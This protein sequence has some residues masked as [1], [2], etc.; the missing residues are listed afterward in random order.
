MVPEPLED[1]HR[2]GGQDEDGEAEVSRNIVLDDHD[3]DPLTIVQQS[4]E[5]ARDAFLFDSQTDKPLTWLDQSLQKSLET[6]PT[7]LSSEMEKRIMDVI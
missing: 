6:V 7:L 1:N 3:Q 5:Q 4:I 2:G